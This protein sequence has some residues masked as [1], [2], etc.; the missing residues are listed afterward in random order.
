[1]KVRDWLFENN[2]TSNKTCRNVILRCCKGENKSAYGY[3][4]KYKE[5]PK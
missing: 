3:I 5:L 1:M 2:I 4:W